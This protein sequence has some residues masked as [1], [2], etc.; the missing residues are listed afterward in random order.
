MGH[1]QWIGTGLFWLA[2]VNLAVVL[3]CLV[4]V[5]V[6][7]FLCVRHEYGPLTEWGEWPTVLLIAPARNEE[8]NIEQA[9]R[10]LAR[11]DY[12]SLEI[13]IIDDRSTD[14]TGEILDRLAAEFPQLNVV[15]LT[16]LP[17][18]WLGKNY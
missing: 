8:R 11:L 16:E 13:T 14:R 17:P 9:V 15:H 18:G 6:R 10:S 1:W 5:I 4:L 12:P 2:L 7:R 3:G